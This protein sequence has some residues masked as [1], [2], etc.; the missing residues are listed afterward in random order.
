MM[1]P[2]KE[3]LIVEETP[4][5]K[6]CLGMP[7]TSSQSKYK[8]AVLLHFPDKKNGALL[9]VTQTD[10]G[11]YRIQIP[12]AWLESRERE[13]GME[14]QGNWLFPGY[15][16]SSNAHSGLIMVFSCVLCCSPI[17]HWWASPREDKRT[18]VVT[19]LSTHWAGCM[20]TYGIS[21]PPRG[22]CPGSCVLDIQNLGND[23]NILPRTVK[24]TSEKLTVFFPKL[25]LKT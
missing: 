12:A 14:L 16:R 13:L 4:F 15:G 20:V 3:T 17:R 10:N 6:T 22:F 2:V 1:V 23:C 8:Q 24:Y 21:L 19:S 18:W 11:G 9:R 25:N 7:L 5:D